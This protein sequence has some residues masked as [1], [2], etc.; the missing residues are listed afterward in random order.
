MDF[1][2]THVYSYYDVQVT[3]RLGQPQVDEYY[4]YRPLEPQLVETN[5]LKLC[6]FELL[7]R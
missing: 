4:S 5:V 1:S 6:S 7:Y 2:G 3:Q